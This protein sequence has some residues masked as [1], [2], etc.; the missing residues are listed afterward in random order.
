[1]LV[2][3][4]ET[5]NTGKPLVWFLSFNKDHW[6]VSGAY[7]SERRSKSNYHIFDLWDGKITQ[8]DHAL[9][10][11]LIVESI[12]E[13]AREVYRTDIVKSLLSLASEPPLSLD[14][15]PNL[16]E[17]N[18]SPESLPVLEDAI[19]LSSSINSSPESTAIISVSTK[20]MAK[21]DLRS[22]SDHSEVSAAQ[23]ISSQIP[24]NARAEV[25]APQVASRGSDEQASQTPLDTGVDNVLERRPS[26]PDDELDSVL[27]TLMGSFETASNVR[28]ARDYLTRL[29]HEDARL[30]PF[31]SVVVK[32][33]NI[34]QQGLADILNLHFKNFANNLVEE[35]DAKRGTVNREA[36]KLIRHNARS[37]AGEI[38]QLSQQ[39]KSQEVFGT[40]HLQ[41]QDPGRSA[42]TQ[43][44]L[45]EQEISDQS[46]NPD[47]ETLKRDE[48]EGEAEGDVGDDSGSDSTISEQLDHRSLVLEGF[49]KLFEQS[50]S[51]CKL[52]DSLWYSV[53][54]NLFDW[55]SINLQWQEELSESAPIYLRY[56]VDEDI[57]HITEE[58]LELTD[59][60]KLELERFTGKPWDWSPL[61][62]PKK[63]IATG[64][65]RLEWNAVSDLTWLKG[66]L[67]LQDSVVEEPKASTCPHY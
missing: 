2:A 39:E 18:F 55:W 16:Q 14:F 23:L 29:F 54:P 28:A 37:L 48:G 4:S 10:L 9:Q 66:D 53:Q 22:I 19:Q 38:A 5:E 36:C 50:N 26:E 42:L 31:F 43:R 1:M 12:I 3:R 57:H 52:V 41:S 62:P 13:W 65:I 63:P 25:N 44:F 17:I 64:K 33:S 6:R 47:D 35:L 58:V 8:K 27:S 7:V 51:F 60:V 34:G 24:L 21:E 49:L 20:E 45:D 67:D 40:L 56:L 61:K 30:S 32:Y 15:E 46:L 11:L 59:K